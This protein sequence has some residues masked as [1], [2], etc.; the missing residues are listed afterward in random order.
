M[1]DETTL[2]VPPA[3]FKALVYDIEIVNAIPD[4]NS[5]PL[6]GIRYCEGWHDHANMGVA[7]LCAYDYVEDRYR[8]FT[9]GNRGDFFDLASRRDLLV[10]FNTV[11]FDNKVLDKSWNIQLGHAGQYDIL[12][13]IWI[14][15]GL[16]P[17]GFSRAHGGFGLDAMAK[18]NIEG[19]SGKTGNGALAPVDWQLGKIGSVIDYCLEDVRLT[20]LLFDKILFEGALICPKTGR[21]ISVRKP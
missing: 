17:D 12:R 1:N 7:V 11:K 20:K 14:A 6:P 3:S 9:E 15:E 21:Y 10:G 19:C 8:V 5:A 16:N 4:R 18:T 2:E 13:E